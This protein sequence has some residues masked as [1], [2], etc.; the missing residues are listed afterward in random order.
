MGLNFKLDKKP[1]PGCV[2]AVVQWFSGGTGGVLS[3]KRR[4]I[5]SCHRS[6][7]AARTAAS[8]RTRYWSKTRRKWTKLGTLGFIGEP[9]IAIYN[10]KTGK[11]VRTGTTRTPIRRRR[12]NG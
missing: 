7:K 11:K 9:H 1:T 12:T 3:A 5:V 8:E 2:Y 6:V 10:I 4:S